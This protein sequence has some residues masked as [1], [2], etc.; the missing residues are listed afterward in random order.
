MGSGV[1]LR[2]SVAD[3]AFLKDLARLQLLSADL[4]DTYHYRHLKGGSQRSLARLE[5]AGLISSQW[6]YQPGLAPLRVYQFASDPVARAYG[7]RLPVTGAKRTELHELLTS[8]AYYALRQPQDFR[9]AANFTQEDQHQCG[10]LRPD[11]LYSEAGETVLVEADSGHYSRGQINQK[12]NRWRNLGLTR[13]VW[14]QPAHRASSPVPLM[15][16]SK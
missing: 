10:S 12:V 5:A 13:Q 16:E 11:A 9:V 14:A 3:R 2:L 6:L 1:T 7:G 8:R 15:P 4:A